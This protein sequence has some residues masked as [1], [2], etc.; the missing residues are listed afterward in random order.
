MWRLIIVIFPI[1]VDSEYKLGIGHL[2]K[3]AHPKSYSKVKVIFYGSEPIWQDLS[4][5]AGRSVLPRTKM[6]KLKAE[7]GKLP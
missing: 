7:A 6:I 2:S 5:Y 3:Y 4:L 1:K